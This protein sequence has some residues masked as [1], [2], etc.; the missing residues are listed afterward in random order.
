MKR[1]L[2]SDEIKAIELDILL[3][4]DRICTKH[5]L[6]YLLAYGTCLGAIRHNGF[7]PWDDDIDVFMPRDDYERLYALFK[8]GGVESPYKLVS[9]RDKSS[10]YQFF[11]L[12]DPSTE[13]YE[14]FVGK[15]H[16][17]GLWVD[18]FPLERVNPSSKKEL[19]TLKR[20]YTLVELK[21]S[22]AVADP[23]VASTPIIKLAK[24][25]IC[26]IARRIY[27]IPDLNHR[28]EKF[29]LSMPE[30]TKANETDL[31]ET[32]YV[33]DLLGEAKIIEAS[34][35]FPVNKASFEGHR[36]PVPNQP[37]KY[38]EINYNNWKV[39]PPE[40]ERALHFPEAYAIDKE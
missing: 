31:R 34:V 28:L 30:I 14:T 25:I 29:A 21:R 4:L 19:N 11:K 36:L 35:L 18:I 22:F 37:E 9:H 33:C 6:T 38:L 24:K 27:S 39:L 26:P 8:N 12:V 17:I 2:S 7:I 40:N 15:K 3:D 32:G 20:M 13:S 16:P 23:S 10:I 1:R 5:G